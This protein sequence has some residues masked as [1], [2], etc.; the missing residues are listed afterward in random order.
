[1]TVTQLRYDGRY[2]TL[3]PIV[4]DRHYGDTLSVSLRFQD[5][6]TVDYVCQ[7]DEESEGDVECGT[8]GYRLFAGVRVQFAFEAS[9]W[10]TEWEGSVR[11]DRL[12]LTY[13]LEVHGG[14]PGAARKAVVEGEATLVFEPSG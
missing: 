6:S 5:H 2:R 4:L 7:L 1:M 9:W 11:E 10:E 8:V 13:R 12:L 14:G 3:M